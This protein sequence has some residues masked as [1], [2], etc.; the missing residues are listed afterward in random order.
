MPGLVS[1]VLNPD[2]IRA[3]S[4]KL[5]QRPP[6]LRQSPQL[7]QVSPT[8]L[9][10]SSSYAPPPA[11]SPPY[12]RNRSASVLETQSNSVP[13]PSTAIAAAKLPSYSRTRIIELEGQK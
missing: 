6:Q 8:K 7:P 3:S 2:S 5:P 11:A 1:A 9:A 12:M 10:H 13:M 4:A